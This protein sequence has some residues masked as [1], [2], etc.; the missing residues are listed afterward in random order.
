MQNDILK[1]DYLFEISWEVCNKVG[2]IH[3]VLSS[4]SDF[5]KNLSRHI[6]IGPDL[7]KEDDLNPEFIEDKQMMQSWRHIAVTEELGVRLGR[8]NIE[9]KPLVILVNHSQFISKKDEIF[10]KYWETFKLDS[11]SGDWGYIEAALFGYA[12]GKVIESFVR[13]NCTLTDKITAHFHEW[14]SGAGL[15]YL[16]DRTPRVACVFTTHATVVGR[17]IAGNNLPLYDK[18]SDYNADGIAGDY[19]VRSQHSMEKLSAR[20]ADCF[21]TVSEITAKECTAFLGRTPDV[22]TPNGFSAKKKKRDKHV[23]LSGRKKMIEAAESLLGFSVSDNALIIGTGSRYEFKNKGLDIFI[24]ALGE[25]N[26]NKMSEREILA[27]LFVPAGQHGPSRELLHKINNPDS[28]VHLS[29]RFT[30]HNLANQYDDPILQALYQNGINNNPD[31]RVKVI[32]VPAY[33]NGN[34]GIFN[35]EYYDLLKDLDLSVFPSYYEPWGY[36]PLESIAF[37]TPTVTSD[38]TGFGVWVMN[39]FPDNR[40]SVEVIV[41]N[42]RNAD[43]AGKDLIRLIIDRCKYTEEQVSEIKNNALQIAENAKWENFIKYYIKAYETALNKSESRRKDT[44]KTDDSVPYIVNIPRDSSQ[45]WHQIIVNS[46]IPEKLRPLDEL[47]RNLWWSW[48]ND[49]AALFKSIDPNLWT[50][51]EYNPIMMLDKISLERFNEL[52]KDDEFLQR[53]NAVHDK[54]VGYMS[55]KEE[56]GKRMQVAYFSME[57]GLHSSLKIYSGGLGVLAGD[58][59]K[60]AGDK[61]VNMT[62]V[63]LLYRYGYFMQ[64]LS[65]AGDQ[66]AEYIAQKFDKI[67][68]SPVRDN[69]GNW[70]TIEIAFPGRMLYAKLWRVDAGRTELYLL[71]TDIEDNLPEDRAVTYHLYGGDRENRLKQE[72]LLGVGGIRALEKLG[73][74]ADV[75]HCNEGHAA[76]TGLERIHG[77]MTKYNLSFDEAKESVRASSLFTTHTPVPAGHDLFE[78]SMLRKYI[79]HY[80]ERF[81]VSWERIMGLGKMNPDDAGE[82]FSMSC[83]AANLSQEMNGVSR[84][85]G[86]VSRDMFQWMFPGYLPEELYIGY[87]TN[88][89][90]YPTWTAGRW[91][92]LYNRYFGKDFENHNYDKSCF[93]NIQRVEDK[94]IWDVRNEL[95]GKLVRYIKSLFSGQNNINYYSPRETVAIKETLDETKLTIVFARRFAT[96]KR[97]HLLFK[98]LDQLNDLVNHPV[99]PVQFIFAGKAHP[100]DKAGQDLIKMIVEIS[101]QPRFLGK[102]LFIENYDTELAAKMV[103]GADVWL[104]TPTRPL[105]ASGTSGQKAVMNGCLHFSVS[106]GWW[107]EGY[108]PE[109]GWALPPECTYENTDFQNELDAETVYSI[110]ENEIAPLYYN[111]SENDIPVEWVRYIK[112]SIEKVA[113]DFT[114]N[115]MMA[116]YEERYYKKLY[117]RSKELNADDFQTARDITM[118]KHKALREWENIVV[119]SVKR[120]EM[121]KGPILLGKEYEA[122]VLLNIGFLTPEDIGVEILLAEQNDGEKHIVLQQQFTPARCNGTEVMYKVVMIPKISGTFSAAI[123]IYAKNDLLPH[124][125]DFCLVK[126][127]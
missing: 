109:A 83:L 32:F 120:P 37:G 121:E 45:K 103:S 108:K 31:D 44:L 47:S 113:S 102:I 12:A 8:W 28:E 99:R 1:P 19:N 55:K 57:Y 17:C 23:E 14:M 24:R 49:A 7:M 89:V 104:N 61:G 25:I 127:V 69:E 21:T 68:V 118:W 90:H 52:E 95:R 59:M 92:T 72:I 110:I 115:R 42:D 38:L 62:G 26:G 96:Y 70:I 35:I 53:M 39:N 2:G 91:K 9:G 3:T 98:N 79:S 73:I 40:P 66:V 76:M 77:L 67:P 34:D 33:L 56:I 4:K 5:L 36:T 107:V 27:F 64:K 65:S 22:I 82:K 43:Q 51:V 85:H 94:K 114:S 75:Y 18:T 86:K 78:E 20:E 11:I 10:K 126:W 122:E 116:D 29:N 123:R 111:R 88:G 97:A 6:F 117:K 46:L 119:I 87:V 125:Q 63:G 58:Y 124:R 84:L 15:L 101:K 71:D 41:R 48:N 60:E 13:F 50:K 100:A 74:E 81:R 16:R 93:G 30:T 106:D 112:N 105:E 80:P 54:F